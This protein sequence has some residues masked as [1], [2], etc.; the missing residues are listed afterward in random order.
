MDLINNLK[1]KYGQSIEA[2][3][4]YCGNQKQKLEDLDRYEENF[5]RAKAEVEKS[6]AQL[7]IVSDKLSVIRKKYSQML[8]DK[9]IEGLK[10]LNF[11]DVQF[12]IDF[13]RKKNIQIMGLMI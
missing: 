8:T 12:H 5:R 13:Q 10:D 1:A 7:E 3:H 11:L 9:I 2:I 4:T 6:R